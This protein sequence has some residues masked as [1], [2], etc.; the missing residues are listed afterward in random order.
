MTRRGR[1]PAPASSPRCRFTSRS[2]NTASMT[3]SALAKPGSRRPCRTRSAVSRWYSGRVR[4]RRLRRSSRM[5]VA[6]PEALAHAWQVGVLAC[7]TSTLGVERRGAG[8]ARAH[9]PRPDDAD[10]RAPAGACHRAGRDAVILL[11]RGRGEEDLAPGCAI[12]RSRRARRSAMRLVREPCRPCRSTGSTRTASSAASGAGIVAT[13]LRQDL[14]SA[15]CDRPARG[16]G[17]CR[18]AATPTTPPRRPRDAA[19]RPARAARRRAARPRAGSLGCTSSSTRPIFQALAARSR[20]SREDDVERRAHADE[21]RQAIAAAG[22]GNE[23]ELHFGKSELGLR[24]IGRDALVAGE[25]E[26]DPAAQAGCR[27]SRRPPASG[28][29]P[30]DSSGP[31]PGD[32][33]AVASSAVCGAG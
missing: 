25:R 2:S 26:F 22:A 29:R 17:R 16:P 30:R 31:A 27:E 3:R 5:S 12:P 15:P 14:L 33:S 24:M 7:R 9:E 21:P 28:R 19:C 6:P 1:P 4:R 11:E 13:G 32:S 8:D 10:A 23:A 18:R 20:L